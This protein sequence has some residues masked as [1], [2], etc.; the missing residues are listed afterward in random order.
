MK[1]PCDLVLP[2]RR[3]DDGE[4]GD[5]DRVCSRMAQS[6]GQL[7]VSVEY[8]LAPNHRFPVGFED[9]YAAAKHF[10]PVRSCREYGRS[11]SP[12]WETVQEAISPR[13]VC[14]KAR[15][16][17]DFRPQRQILIYPR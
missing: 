5:Y 10:L 14:M 13:A 11:R 17:G 4:C 16:T 3:L 7:V 15:D 6:I 8:R 9:C 2:R 12:S 1:C